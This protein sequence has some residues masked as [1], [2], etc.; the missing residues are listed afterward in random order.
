MGARKVGRRFRR[1][2]VAA[3]FSAA[4]VMA[5][6]AV[7]VASGDVALTFGSESTGAA[8]AGAN[9]VGVDDFKWD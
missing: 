6:P 8:P 7:A 2:A 3:T 5:L 4:V 9:S 1:A